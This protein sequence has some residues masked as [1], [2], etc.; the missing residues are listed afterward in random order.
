[1]S[2]SEIK[3][4]VT[5]LAKEELNAEIQKEAVK[6]LKNK[7]KQLH[8]AKVIVSNLERELADLEREI[9]AGVY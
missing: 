6:K 4:S 3:K 2:V 8:D 1:M 9:E 5:A 7:L